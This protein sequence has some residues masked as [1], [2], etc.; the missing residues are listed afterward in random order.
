MIFCRNIFLYFLLVLLFA[1]SPKNKLSKIEQSNIELNSK[2]KEDSIALK[3]IAPYKN[4]M[5]DEMEEVLI[6]SENEAVKG[7]PEGTLGNVVSDIV[8]KQGNIYCERG[9]IEKADI[10]LLNNG[11]L[12]TTLPKGAITTGKIFELM[13]FE[14]ELVILTLSGK[15]TL[16]MF[17][18][19]AFQS[20]MPMAGAKM[21][22]KK[23]KATNILINNIAIDT[24]RSYRVITSDYLSNGGDKMNFF[25]KPE[26]T[27]AINHKIRDGIIEYLRAE[28]KKGNT[29]KPS[30]DGRIKFE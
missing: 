7:D 12:R 13:P 22:I 25:S 3:L 23:G 4:K 15:K 26:K 19:I 14:N 10:C 29:L 8:L 1:C 18:Y 30:L 20:G 6:V 21:T 5:K 27:E 11:G 16:S 17:N 2:N 9:H 28:N 24:S